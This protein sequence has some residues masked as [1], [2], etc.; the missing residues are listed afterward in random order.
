MPIWINHRGLTHP[1]STYSENTLRAFNTAIVAGFTHLE[2]DLRTS[3]DGHIVLVHDANLSRLGSA[4]GTSLT[5]ETSTRA[6]LSAITLKC[7]EPLLFFDEWL[8]A[9]HAQYWILD[10]KPESAL[11]TLEALEPFWR[12]PRFQAFFDSHVRFLFWHTRHQSHLLQNHPKAQCLAPLHAC[13]QAAFA[14]WLHLPALGNIKAHTTY[15]IPP[16]FA[17]R[18]VISRRVVNAYHARGARVIG[19]L[20]E[21]P[22]QTQWLL[23]A[24]VNEILTNHPPLTK[25]TTIAEQM[26]LNG[27]DF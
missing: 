11:R 15:A 21:T 26:P 17:R 12:Q 8:E 16:V 1:H 22:E 10:I 4:N 14:T 7:G 20:P 9:F 25:G 2:T 13:Q 6:E 19:Y 24:G 5:I 18:P 3:V 27:Q 23:E